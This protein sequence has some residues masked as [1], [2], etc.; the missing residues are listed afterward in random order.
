MKSAIIVIENFVELLFFEY[1][2]FLGLLYRDLEY[3]HVWLE[4]KIV[5]QSCNL[6][7]S[8]TNKFEKYKEVIN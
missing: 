8:Q 4:N 2:R 3:L 6:L 7:A 1:H 5:S